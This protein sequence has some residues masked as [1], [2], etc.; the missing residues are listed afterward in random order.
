MKLLKFKGYKDRPVY[1]VASCITGF[2]VCGTD[3][4]KVFISTGPD[5]REGG[6]NG[7]IVCNT[8]EEV[9]EIIESA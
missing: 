9:K 4:S 7:W 2:C 8:M 6:E 1:V 5:D 3:E